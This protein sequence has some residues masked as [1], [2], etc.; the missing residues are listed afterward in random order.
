MKSTQAGV[1]IGTRVQEG[2]SIMSVSSLGSLP[3]PLFHGLKVTP[4]FFPVIVHFTH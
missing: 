3:V 1:E 4:G 2:L